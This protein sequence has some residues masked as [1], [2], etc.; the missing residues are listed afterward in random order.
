MTETAGRQ[1]PTRVTFILIVLL[2]LFTAVLAPLVVGN[3]V[4]TVLG[5]PQD[6]VF[7]ITKTPH[8]EAAPTHTDL[9]TQIVALGGA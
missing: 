3:V 4:V 6:Q 5:S 8:S 1:W 9:F 2:L 7:V